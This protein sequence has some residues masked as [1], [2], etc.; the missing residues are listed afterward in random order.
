MCTSKAGPADRTGLPVPSTRSEIPHVPWAG[1]TSWENPGTG[2]LN[3]FTMLCDHVLPSGL[4]CS[5]I[6]FAMVSQQVLYQIHAEALLSIE[7]TLEGRDLTT[8]YSWGQG[9]G[10]TWFFMP[11]PGWSL[12][13]GTYPDLGFEARHL[14]RLHSWFTQWQTVNLGQA[15]DCK[16]SYT[17]QLQWVSAC[18]CERSGFTP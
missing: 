1:G 12:R 14:A 15:L 3:W 7:L 18:R 11:R 13:A 10:Q 8:V 4:S 5:V 2:S 6:W 16:Q 17:S 9:L